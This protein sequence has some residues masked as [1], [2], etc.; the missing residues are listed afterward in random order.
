MADYKDIIIDTLMQQDNYITAV[1]LAN[2]VNCSVRTVKKSIS[3]INKDQQRLIIT[4]QK[5]Y[6]LN[7]DQSGNIERKQ[8]VCPQTSN[9]RAIY[10]LKTILQS[11]IKSQA[12]DI[13][14]F[15]EKLFVSEATIKRALI[16][17]RNMCE[18]YNLELNLTGEVISIK[19]I[20]SNKRKL[21]SSFYY[22]EF[23]KK[24]LSLSAIQKVF[25][26]YDIEWIK[27]V[28]IEKCKSHHYYVNGYTLINLVLD[29]VISLDRIKNNFAQEEPAIYDDININIREK[30]LAKTIIDEFEKRYNITVNEFEL[31]SLT[32]LLISHLL[33]IDYKKLDYDNLDQI[34]GRECKDLVDEILKHAQE[35]C[36]LNID[37]K[38]LYTRFALHISNLLLRAKIHN[39]N[40]YPLTETIKSDCPLLFDCAVSI[41][42]IITDKTGLEIIEDEIAYI[43]LHIGSLLDL[44]SKTINKL[45]VVLLFPQYYDFF[46]RIE[47]KLLSQFGNEIEIVN[48]ITYQDDIVGQ[49]NIDLI[50]S[51]VPINMH[52]HK[53][54]LVVNSLLMDKDYELIS[55]RID[56]IKKKRKKEFILEQLIAISNPSLFEKNVMFENKKEIINYMVTKMVDQGYVDQGYEKGVL[57]REELSST[58][59]GYVAV[60]HSMELNANKTGMYIMLYNKPV[61]WGEKPVQVILLFTIN[62]DEIQ[63][64]RSVFDDIVV[65]LMEME[66]LLKVTQTNSYTEFLGKI[67]SLYE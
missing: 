49:S 57:H 56:A 33:K 36:L 45:K 58:A 47:K 3:D 38:E 28:I 23:E 16:I 31:N 12:F 27:N 34:I 52:N 15:S 39:F 54:V 55:K 6:K 48:V 21:M 51:T 7:K 5:G 63:L 2:L 46:S 19:G 25:V 18:S 4:S 10:I 40:K 24:D 66:N 35:Y 50:I 53:N 43:A 62:K 29:V 14:D 67:M 8:H 60:P 44:D 26:D 20:E 59:F 17:A 9:D 11:G 37:D 30:V 13:Y 32:L 22:K 41:S 42:K 64:F 65:L 1:M 61:M